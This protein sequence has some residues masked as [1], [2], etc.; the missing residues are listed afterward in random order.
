[1]GIGSQLKNTGQQAQNAPPAFAQS[2][3]SQQAQN[4]SPAF[5]QSAGSQTPPPIVQQPS[6]PQPMGGKGALQS[7]I[8]QPAFSQQAQ[9]QAFT[10]SASP[11]SIPPQF[12]PQQPQPMGGKGALQSAVQPNM[13][14]QNP[15]LVEA[16]AQ[17]PGAAPSQIAGKGQSLVQPVPIANGIEQPDGQAVPMPM[18][19]QQGRYSRGLG[20]IINQMQQRQQPQ[21]Q[22]QDQSQQRGGFLSRFPRQGIAQMSS[23]G[24]KGRL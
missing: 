15:Q 14:P 24:G 9:N 8:Q 20:G 19:E 10:Q 4:A 12:A 11:Q 21:M 2:A 1:M 5:S 7:A 3:F 23:L 17:I 13:P 16:Q 22:M 18:I 6:Y